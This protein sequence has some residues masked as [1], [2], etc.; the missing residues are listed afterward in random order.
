MVRAGRTVPERADMLQLIKVFSFP[1]LLFASLFTG[2]AG[3]YDLALTVAACLAATVLALGA[4]RAAK[5]VW[6]AEL[7]AI[8]IVFSPILLLSKVFLLMG[9]AF[10]VACFGL[11]TAL[12]A[13][14]APAWEVETE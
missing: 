4:L 12:R 7:I 5:Y 1:V 3:K 9:L 8:A 14:P 13:Q 10:G 2:Y 6:A 11:W